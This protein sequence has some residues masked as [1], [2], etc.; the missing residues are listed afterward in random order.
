METLKNYLFELCADSAPSGREDLLHSLSRLVRPLADK[1]YTDA[2]GNLV[3]VKYCNIPGAGKILIDA[4]ADEV[5][6]IVT[7]VDDNGFVHFANHAGIDCKVLPAATVTVLGKRPLAG[8]VA[9]MP[10]HLLK[11][12]DTDKPVKM[13][14]SVIDIGYDAKTA[15]ELVRVGDL[16]SLRSNTAEL[17]NNRVMGGSLDN[18]ASVAVLID[19]MSKLKSTHRAHSDVY[20]VF[21]AGEE[22]GGYGAAAAAFDIA[23]DEAIVL[24]VTFGVSPYTNKQKGKDLGSGAAIGVSP[25]LDT[26]NTEKMIDTAKAR[27]IPYTLEIMNG[28]TGTNADGIVISR[29]GVPTTLVSIPLRYMHSPSEV[30]CLEDMQSVSRLVMSYIEYR[31][32]VRFE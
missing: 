18:R 30:V 9:T 6:L 21:S 28:R 22:F 31:G 29:D 12:A 2:S 26:H 23:P 11:D 10:P 13:K 20:F 16:I 3:A 14:D 5:A 17:L 32:G 8:V 4:H 7:D 24:D 25:M 15:R 27:N 19:V 1:V